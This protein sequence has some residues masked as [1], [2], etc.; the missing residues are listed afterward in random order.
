MAKEI[1]KAK[2]LKRLDRQYDA[3]FQNPKMAAKLNSRLM[4]VENSK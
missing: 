4:T 3:H 2:K 1:S